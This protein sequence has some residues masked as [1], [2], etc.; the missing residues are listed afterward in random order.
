MLVLLNP[1]LVFLFHQIIL[2]S[3]CGIVDLVTLFFLK[4]FFFFL[5]DCI[6]NIDSSKPHHCTIYPLAKQLKPYFPIFVN[7]VAA[8]FELVHCDL[9]G[10]F[11]AQDSHGAHFFLTIV[12]DFSCCTWVYLLNSKS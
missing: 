4:C 3:I 9:W 2:M 5:K 11:A 1:H 12:D 10:S 8:I 7:K 6:S